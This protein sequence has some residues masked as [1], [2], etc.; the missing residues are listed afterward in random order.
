MTPEAVVGIAAGL[1]TIMGAAV[2]VTRYITGLQY[3][4]R[5]EKLQ[6]ERTAAQQQ[7]R[8]LDARYQQ[9]VN[10]VAVSRRIGTAALSRKRDVDE[11]LLALMS[12]MQ[13]GAGSVYI[14]LP[15]SSPGENPPGL[16]FLSIQ[17]FGENT[18]SLQK[19]T[20]PMQSLAGRCFTT[21]KPFARPDTES[22]ADHF[23]KADLVSGYKTEDAVNMPLSHQGRVI[24]VLQLLN[25][26]GGSNFTESDI[27]RVEMLSDA[28]VNKVVR[29]L[30][31][32][33]NLQIL[34]V[35]SEPGGQYAT[36]LFCDLSKSSV[37]FKE[38][39]AS[40]A[41]QHI[42]EYLEAVCD[43]AMKHGATVDKY[44]GD[45]VL[46]RFNVPRSVE[47]HPLAAA[48]AA[49]EMKAA[50]EGLKKNWLTM[51]EVIGDVHLRVGLSCGR[52]H[53]ATIG[54]P[55]YQQLTVIGPP[56]SVAVN[57]CEAAIRDRGIIVLDE[58]A[59]RELQGRVVARRL[60][61]EQL[62]KA[63]RFISAAYELEQLKQ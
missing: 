19:K 57:L 48:R 3:K 38:L 17:P 39:N 33:N 55:Q 34:G 11:E 43:V 46:L 26:E 4:I 29:F 24:G 47:N 31:D 35:T 20:I 63:A 13:A 28:L 6:A 50:F 14:S 21:G 27:P 45:G 10:E 7:F 54:H 8:D 52:V 44:M 15:T 30:E 2:A 22:D 36:T 49:L 18:A 53:Q 9:L 5:E 12:A 32:P 59:Q 56:V 41:I 25:R 61:Q 62:G 42:N 60:P 40:S 1:V 58:R 37:L 23:K 16:M 51:G